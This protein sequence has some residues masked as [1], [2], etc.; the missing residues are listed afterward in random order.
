MNFQRIK[1][2]AKNVRDF[3]YNVVDP[4]ANEIEKTDQIPQFI[5]DKGKEMGLFGLS[6]P[7]EYGGL[8]LSTVSKFAILEEVGRTSNAYTTLIGGHNGIGTVGIVEMGNEERKRKYL[9]KIYLK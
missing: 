1:L 7:E 8:G 4:L 9:L 2:I 5:V 3:V 6:I